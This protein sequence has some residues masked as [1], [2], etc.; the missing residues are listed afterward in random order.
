MIGAAEGAGLQLSHRPTHSSELVGTASK[1]FTVREDLELGEEKPPM[2]YIIR[3]SEKIRT[4][5]WKVTGGKI[6]V[7]GELEVF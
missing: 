3:H 6:I 1:K 7:K 4:T 5:D 2:D